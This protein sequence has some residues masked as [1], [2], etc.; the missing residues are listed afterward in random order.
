MATTAKTSTIVAA[1]V[2]TVVTGVVAY[3]AYF[4]HRRRTDAEFRKSLKR[5]YRKEARAAKEEAEAEGVKK[6]RAIRQ[7][8]DGANEEGFP[9]SS[10]EVEAYFMQEVAKG[11]ALCQSGI[12]PLYMY[13]ETI[14]DMAF[15]DSNLIE[16]ALC[17]YKALKV[18][19]APRDLISIYDKTVPKVRVANLEL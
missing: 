13:H 4:D 6:R 19:P 10:E 14:T 1:C 7:A 16:A 9:K 17:F 8:V 18:Y 12:V 5:E 3:A 15:P 2:G 11:E